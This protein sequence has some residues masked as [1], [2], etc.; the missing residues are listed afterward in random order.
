MSCEFRAANDGVEPVELDTV[1]GRKDGKVLFTLTLPS[2]LMLAFLRDAKTSQTC[3]RIFNQIWD[4]AGARL[5]RRMFPANEVTLSPAL[6]GSKF[7]RIA[8]KAVMKKHGAK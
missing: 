6:L 4:A 3:T 1:I 2:K 7:R 5:F 8:N